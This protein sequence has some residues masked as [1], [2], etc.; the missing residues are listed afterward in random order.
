MYAQQVIAAHAASTVTG[1]HDLD[2]Y[3]AWAARLGLKSDTAMSVA[4]SKVATVH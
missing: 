3:L 1:A 4:G 2:N